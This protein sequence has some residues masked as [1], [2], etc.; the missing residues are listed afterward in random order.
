MG[1]SA[2]LRFAVCVC[3]KCETGF[4]GHVILFIC[5]GLKT[6]IDFDVIEEMIPKYGTT[7]V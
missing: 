1:Y 3:F 2:L 5:V 7:T 4:F 6:V